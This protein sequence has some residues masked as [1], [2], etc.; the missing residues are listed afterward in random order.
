[1]VNQLDY[2]KA[3]ELASTAVLTITN[4]NECFA[5]VRFNAIMQA[6]LGVNSPIN[7]INIPD[8]SRGKE[9]VLFLQQVKKFG[10]SEKIVT[11]KFSGGE[12][13]FRI[14]GDYFGGFTDIYIFDVTEAIKTQRNNKRLRFMLSKTISPYISVIMIIGTLIVN[15]VNIY[16][17]NKTEV[18]LNNYEVIVN[19][20]I[21]FFNLQINDL[22]S[23]LQK[24]K[25]LIVEKENEKRNAKK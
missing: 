12:K 13:Q 15:S 3:R 19:E 17:I 24:T 8:F 4:E 22:E 18:Q 25:K 5:S 6:I 16:Y 1:M 9:I 10:Q 14:K 11:V 23:I 7:Y 21:K 20:Q 2:F